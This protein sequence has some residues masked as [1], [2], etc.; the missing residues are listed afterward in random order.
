MQNTTGKLPTDLYA[1]DN[2]ELQNY[3]SAVL[4]YT[5]MEVAVR[6]YG[7]PIFSEHQTNVA[8]S[9]LF[10]ESTNLGDQAYEHSPSLPARFRSR[11]GRTAPLRL[12]FPRQRTRGFPWRS[13]GSRRGASQVWSLPN[14]FESSRSRASSPG[15]RAKQ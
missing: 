5:P 2:L 7:T 6:Y 4:R 13:H 12:R 15:Q 3:T 10:H 11:V 1:L 8:Y 14:W 9:Q